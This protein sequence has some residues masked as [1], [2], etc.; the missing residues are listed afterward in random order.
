[1][2][3]VSPVEGARGD[4][5]K[6]HVSPVEG[7]RGDTGARVSPVEGARGDTGARTPHMQGAMGVHA[8]RDDCH[9]L[10]GQ[11]EGQVGLVRSCVSAT[12]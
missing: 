5:D 7:A 4:A 2:A 9:A 3:C 10:R 6:A 8:G 12:F 1:M 11:C